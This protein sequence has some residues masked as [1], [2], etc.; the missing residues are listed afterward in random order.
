VR[1]FDGTTTTIPAE[2]LLSTTV[3]NWRSVSASDARSINRSIKLDTSSIKVCDQ[4]LLKTISTLP[5]MQQKADIKALFD[6]KTAASNLTLFKYYSN[7]YLSAQ[8]ALCKNE[9]TFLIKQSEFSSFSSN[10]VLELEL[11]IFAKEPDFDRY[12][13]LQSRIIENL[14]TILPKFGLQTF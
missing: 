1:N 2:L 8:Q 5:L 7:L 14:T 12:N 4:D 3:R 10:E 13:A 6:T 11:H 9:F